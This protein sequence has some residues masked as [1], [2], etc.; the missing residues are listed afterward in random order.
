MRSYPI[1]LVGLESRRCIVVGGGEVAQRKVEGL[2]EGG[3]EG[4][5]VI[6]PRLTRK[7]KALLQAGRIEHWPRGYRQGDL[8][9]AFVVIAATN[10]PE[11]NRRVW[12]EAEQ[13]GLLVNVVDE[14]QGC[15]FFVPSVVRRGDLTISICT[16][17]QDPALSARLRRELEPRFGPEYAAFLEIAGALRE[18]VGRELSGRAR[19]RFWYALADSQVLALLKDGRQREAERLANEIL[20]AHAVKGKGKKTPTPS[21]GQR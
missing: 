1:N 11:V 8:E 5:V 19:S 9:G 13:R 21:G 15:N 7:L 4:V 6:S 2:L 16:G 20:A 10:D 18:R 12:Q 17:G 3:A 14:P